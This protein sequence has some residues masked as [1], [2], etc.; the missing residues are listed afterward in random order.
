M[1]SKT[2]EQALEAAIEKALTGSNLEE[3]KA[4]GYAPQQM[5]EGEIHYRSG[6][7]FYIGDPNDY[8]AKWAIDKRR[9]WHFLE[10]SQAE[11]LAKLRKRSDG[12]LKILHR[13]NVLIKKYGVLELL[14]KG[15]DVDDAH[16]EL[17]YP[18]PLASSGER[19][20]Q[21]F[22]QNEFSVSRQLRYSLDKPL[23]EIDMVIFVNGLPIITMELKNPWTGQN[24]RYHGQKQYREDRDIRQPL[25]QFGRCLVH[26]AVDTDE[27]YMT[28]RLAGKGT[29]FLPFNKGNG[30][31]KGNPVNEFGHKTA[32][33]WEQIFK[34]ESLT[35]LIQHFVRFDGKRTTALN[36]RTLY[37]PR[38][39]QLDVVRKIVAD[40]EKEGLGKT[41]LIQHSAGSGKSNSITW[42]AYQLIETYPKHE[43]VR[44]YRGME[45]P[46]FD[47]VIVVTDRRLLDKQIRE[48]IKSFSQVKNIVA[49]AYR[50]AD[51]KAALEMGKKIIITTIQKFPFVLEGIGQMNEK[52][53]A[54]IIDE[55]HSSQTGTTADKMNMTFAKTDDSLGDAQD[56]LFDLMSS[57][58]M[59]QNVSYLAFTATPKNSTLEKFGVRQADGSFKPFHLYSMKQAIEEGF[60]LDV[61]A[62]YTTYKS[63]YEL[64]KS[65][66]EN[67]LFDTKKAQKKL[68]KYVERQE[69]TIATKAEIMLNH[70]MEQ[71]QAKRKLKGKG[72]AMVLTQ[73]IEAA[74]LYYQAMQRLLEQKGN[75]FRIL[76]AFSGKKMLKGIEYT[77]EQ[78]N[79]L[80]AELD[81]AK[82]SDPD[83]ISD[84]IARYF[85]MDEYRI[86]IVANKY[87][88]GFDQPKLCSMYIDKK[89]QGVLA[90]Q[91]LSRL[92]RSA[93]KLGK[94]TED[95]FV[96][97]F[98]NS[99][100]DIKKAFDDFYTA[101]S[102]SEATDVNILHELKDHLED[103]GVYELAE[104][105]EFTNLFFDNADAQ[106]LSP[107]IDQAAHRFNEE[108][109]LTDEEKADYKIKAK[110]F[111]KIYGQLASI[112]DMDYSRLNWEQLF[113]FLK[114]LIPKM[115]IRNK[116]KDQLDSL[117]DAV[118]LST[119]GIERV[120]LNHKIELDA[121]ETSLKPQNANP[122]GAHEEEEKDTLEEILR[123]FNE[124]WFKDWGATPEEQRIR[125]ASFGEGIL[126]HPDYKDKVMENPDAQNR[127]MAFDKI[128]KEVMTHHRKL[129]IQLYRK[130]V[131]D[132]GFA[133]AIVNGLKRYVE[134]EAIKRNI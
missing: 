82:S 26:F 68:R 118:D 58:K 51:L 30:Q 45:R 106:L 6:N 93:N 64:Q 80:P 15:L 129:D 85:D 44:G 35:N 18:L 111:V 7:G 83:Y 130:F 119:Y 75:P 4:Q 133:Q 49:P 125:F 117:L 116:D 59:R 108:L 42:A 48:N 69:R 76:V 122:R 101:T 23:Q 92:N 66:A 62:N 27:V 115:V 47:S 127:D 97:D 81:R 16:F 95:L 94:K 99:T 113:W 71:V 33:L 38:F 96:L 88:T 1:P 9:F 31:S 131:Q 67:P 32:Y 57:R 3:M 128:M 90:V 74:I 73:S 114:F 17:L 77:E 102:L 79:Y 134:Q 5:A 12:E 112:M 84:K 70:F 63:Y 120:K 132:E 123:M 56:K 86:L 39:H 105:K 72:K 14:R 36:K 107:I 20:R 54:V 55:A 87:L 11:E 21:Q 126:N 25:L 34:R 89:L 124:R 65:I 24:A 43:N 8:D 22:E 19:V 100:E 52:Q 110:Q 91:A 28:T 29:F 60:I 61:L 37:F 53:F 103:P 98:F 13:L 10:S 50:S 121:E 78:I 104:V 40:I 41:Y 46:L 109:E 2:N